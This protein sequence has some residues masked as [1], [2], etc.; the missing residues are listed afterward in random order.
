MTRSQDCYG[1]RFSWYVAVKL[2][3]NIEVFRF[4]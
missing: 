1:N 3:S 4:N 2:S